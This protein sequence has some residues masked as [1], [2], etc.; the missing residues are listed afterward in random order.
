MNAQSQIV[1]DWRTLSWPLRIEATKGTPDEPA[2]L[3]SIEDEAAAR[4]DDEWRRAAAYALEGDWAELDLLIHN[5]AAE[6]E[7]D[8]V[9]RHCKEYRDG[10][11]SLNDWLDFTGRS[12]EDF[13]PEAARPA[14]SYVPGRV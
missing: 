10:D 9:A 13:A 1:A 3:A 8:R 11:W 5:G 2:A 6:E 7:A 12:L 14:M 4:G